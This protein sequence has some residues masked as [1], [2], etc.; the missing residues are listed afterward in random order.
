[1]QP[2]SMFV[3]SGDVFRRLCGSDHMQAE[4]CDGHRPITEDISCQVNFPREKFFTTC[5]NCI[6]LQ[7]ASQEASEGV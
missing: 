3:Q 5:S 2:S 1:M 7:V 6:H 4:G